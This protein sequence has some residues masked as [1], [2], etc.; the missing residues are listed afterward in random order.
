MK[1]KT[2][3]HIAVAVALQVTVLMAVITHVM[4]YLSSIQI[5]RSNAT[6]VASGI[7]LLSI[8]GRLG[9]GWLGD[10]FDKRRV[11]A[12]AFVLM[13]FGLLSFAYADD[14][15][16]WLLVPFLILF[17]PGYGGII[18][19]RAALLREYFGR[20]EFGAIHGLVVAIMMPG[21]IAGAPLAGWV[22][23]S[24]GSYHPIWLVFAGFMV[25]GMS[26]MLTMRS[27]RGDHTDKDQAP[28]DWN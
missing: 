8:A 21:S 18:S 26:L 10:T 20:G 12:A 17:G 5:T 9:F 25:T 16:V 2:F 14:T 4:P 15:R 23:D 27:H 19:M 6:L 11:A 3:W 22:F 24:W 13:S 1:S 28:K 7:P